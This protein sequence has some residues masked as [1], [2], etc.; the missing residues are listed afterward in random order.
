[1]GW[2]SD[3]HARSARQYY[4]GSGKTLRKRPRS[5]PLPASPPLL[6]P[7]A[8][9]C[10]QVPASRSLPVRVE[11][12]AV[13]DGPGCRAGYASFK[14]LDESLHPSTHRS[15]CAVLLLAQAGQTSA[16]SSDAAHPM[17][18]SRRTRYPMLLGRQ[19][20]LQMPSTLHYVRSTEQSGCMR[21]AHVRG[22]RIRASIHRSI[23]PAIQL[24]AIQH[25]AHPGSQDAVPPFAS[26]P[27][28]APP[29]DGPSQ[30]GPSLGKTMQ[31]QDAPRA[32]ASTPQAKK[33]L[34]AQTSLHPSTIQNNPW[35]P[36]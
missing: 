14:L 8:D 10:G 34:G 33:K 7:A 4:G 6:R 16:F 28:Q 11:R 2:A 9:R 13:G 15:V 24:P 20:T 23:R 17:D 5:T 32:F 31:R 22:M 29:S 30:F 21:Q 3:S 35:E 1:M 19:S 12:D 25:A 36:W 26:P 18:T 27:A